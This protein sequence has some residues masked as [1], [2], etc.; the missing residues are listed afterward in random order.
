M[1]KLLYKKNLFLL[2]PHVAPFLL[3][4]KSFCPLPLW[5]VQRESLGTSSGE[6]SRYGRHFKCKS[7]MVSTIAWAMWGWASSY[8]N[9]TLLLR[10]HC[11]LDLIIGQ[12][13]F[14][15]RSK[16]VLLVIVSH[17]GIC[18]SK[19]TI[20][21]SQGH[22]LPCRL[23]TAELL[24]VLLREML[25]FLACFL[26]FQLMV[27]DPRLISRNSSHHDA[28][29]FCFKFS[30]TVGSASAA[31]SGFTI[32]CARRV[33]YWTLANLKLATP[34]INLLQWQICMTVLKFQLP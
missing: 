29:T 21:S 17:S 3:T 26:C 11:H 16:Y 2:A 1:H 14:L 7:V 25:S 13:W 30:I 19:I 22:Y 24:W 32:W 20:C 23:L 4:C 8:C 12:R 34:L 6:Y 28:I 5:V 31:D 15:R 33:R 9:K 27:V 10:S 18:S